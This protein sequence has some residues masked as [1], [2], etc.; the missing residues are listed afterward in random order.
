MR[1][2]PEQ[3]AG[4]WRDAGDDKQAGKDAGLSRC[5]LFYGSFISH[6]FPWILFLSMPNANLT[7]VTPGDARRATENL[8]IYAK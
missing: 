5:L 7:E 4:R 2:Q 3:R 6:F 8:L 1:R